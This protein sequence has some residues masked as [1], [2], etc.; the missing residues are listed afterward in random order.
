MNDIKYLI[1]WMAKF[2]LEYTIVLLMIVG[3]AAGLGGAAYAIWRMF[4]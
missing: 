3:W 2:L 4:Q 1:K